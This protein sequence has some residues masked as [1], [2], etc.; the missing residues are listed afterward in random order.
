[1]SRSE[2]PD[3]DCWHRQ[4]PRLAELRDANSAEIGNFFF[5]IPTTIQSNNL[6]R[7]VYAELESDLAELDEA[8]WGKFKEKVLAKYQKKDRGTNA[9]RGYTQVYST[10]LEAKG[11]GHLKQLL[12]ARKIDFDRI[13]AIDECEESRP[14]WRASLRDETVALLEVK[15]VYESDDESKYVYENTRRI[16]S[17]EN[18]IAKRAFPEISQGLVTKLKTT[19]AIAKRQLFVLKPDFQI[20]RIAYLIVHLDDELTDRKENYTDVAAILDEMSEAHFTVAYHFRGL[21]APR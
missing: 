14:D 6:A 18:A 21:N 12:D 10:L 17:G 5:N 8:T 20:P 11:Y 13:E 19:V 9:H 3:Q 16:K 2:Q 15:A 4:F 7:E 1:M